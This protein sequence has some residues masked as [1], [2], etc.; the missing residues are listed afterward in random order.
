[1]FREL[2]GRFTGAAFG[3]TGGGTIRISCGF[4]AGSGL[5]PARPAARRRAKGMAKASSDQA[6]GC[7]VPT[8]HK[9]TILPLNGARRAC[10]PWVA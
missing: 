3:S 10:A 2:G 1:M 6:T 5:K 9:A 8:A 7:G 4:S